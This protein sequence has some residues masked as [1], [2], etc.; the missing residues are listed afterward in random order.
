MSKSLYFILFFLVTVQTSFAFK[1]FAVQHQDLKTYEQ[2]FTA[3]KHK[4]PENYKIY[5]FNG[6]GDINRLEA[7]IQMLQHDISVD[8]VLSL[9]TIAGKLSIKHIKNKPI[10][11]SGIA[12]PGYSGII[13]DWNQSGKNY[14]VIECK[15]ITYKTLRT[16]YAIYKFKNIGLI[17]LSKAPSHIGT[18]KEATAFCNDY[19]VK[20]IS[21]SFDNRDQNKIL[22]PKEI[23]QERL[24]KACLDVIPYVDFLYLNTS[25]TFLQNIGSIIS[26]ANRYEVITIGSNIYSDYGISIE[27][28]SDFFQ[29]GVVA[30]EYTEEILMENT[31]IST[32]PMNIIK[33]FVVRYNY[34]YGTSND[35]DLTT[36]FLNKGIDLQIK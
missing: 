17:Y 6:D 24:I 2:I 5:S 34:F 11:I 9:G 13:Q 15:N 36:K 21:S 8:L 22:L 31:D 19:N 23:I 7:Y 25:N 10:I 29:R 30:A 28:T 27:I 18:F 16:F 3:Y 14:T 12:S 32:L 20:L 33:D 26:L 1:I 35:L 4:L